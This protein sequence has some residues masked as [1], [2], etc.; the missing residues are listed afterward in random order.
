MDYMVHWTSPRTKELQTRLCQ[1]LS[2]QMAHLLVEEQTW[3][4]IMLVKMSSPSPI[5]TARFRTHGASL[6]RPELWWQR[7]LW[8]KIHSFQTCK[9]EL[10]WTSFYS[11]VQP[12]QLDGWAAALFTSSYHQPNQ[13]ALVPSRLWMPMETLCY[14]R[15]GCPLARKEIDNLCRVSKVTLIIWSP[16]KTASRIM[17]LTLYALIWVVL[18]PGTEPPTSTCAHAMVPSTTTL[19]RSSEAPPHS[20]SPSLTSSLAKMTRSAWPHGP[21]LTSELVLPHGGNDLK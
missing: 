4:I 13:V 16:R 5:T 2:H 7:L 21:K 18:S 12:Y 17:Q 11:A 6:D 9:E 3:R 10:S 8:M 14:R 19:A 20:V 1:L 15:L